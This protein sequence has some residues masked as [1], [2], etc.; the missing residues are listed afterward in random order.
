MGEEADRIQISEAPDVA[1]ALSGAPGQFRR[2]V[3]G[4]LYLVG[5]VLALETGIV[6]EQSAQ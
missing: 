3:T 5:E 2:L 4:S 1:S 6:Q